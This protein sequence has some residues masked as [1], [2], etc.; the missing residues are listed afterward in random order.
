[1][2]ANKV[3]GFVAAGE[4]LTGNMDFF[5]L[6]TAI[7]IRVLAAGSAA[8]QARLDKVVEVIAL[9]GQPVIMGAPYVD[10]SDYVFKFAIEHKGTWTATGLRDAIVANQTSGMGFTSGNTSVV[11]TDT[12]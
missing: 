12:L 10:G 7:D 8:S 2:Y 11:I 3:N 1:M 6:T 9:N 4:N 5:V